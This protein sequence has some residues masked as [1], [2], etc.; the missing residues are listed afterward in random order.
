M[1][2]AG[3]LGAVW[4]YTITKV[5]VPEAFKIMAATNAG[6]CFIGPQR[7]ELCAHPN[8]GPKH[9]VPTLLTWTWA[10]RMK[11]ARKGCANS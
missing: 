1:R 8:V 7:G 6:M 2:I 3:Y 9:I 5:P 11:Q 4:M 10:H